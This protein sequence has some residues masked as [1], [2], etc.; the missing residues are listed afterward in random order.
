M[1]DNKA[2]NKYEAKYPYLVH[3]KQ[4][5]FD[6]FPTVPPEKIIASEKKVPETLAAALGG[7]L[8]DIALREQHQRK[9]D[10]YRRRKGIETAELRA[11]FNRS[12]SRTEIMK[13]WANSN[14]PKTRG[15]SG[16]PDEERRL[17]IKLIYYELIDCIKDIRKALD[18]PLTETKDD[19]WPMPA[20]TIEDVKEMVPYA[21]SIF[22]E[23]ELPQLFKSPSIKDAALKII[24]KRLRRFF[25]SSLSI[26]TLQDIIYKTNP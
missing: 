19:D 11:E 26:R 17:I 2:S 6:K 25:Y 22:E 3:W 12:F 24:H 10:E 13:K 16:M 18:V 21:D 5:G 15:G 7:I 4:Q 23:K 1:S 8:G 14:L 20:E 9:I